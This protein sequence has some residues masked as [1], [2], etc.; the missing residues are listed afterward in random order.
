MLPIYLKRHRGPLLVT[1]GE[2][3]FTDPAPGERI[4]GWKSST[5]PSLGVVVP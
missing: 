2:E 5:W 4:R 3:G 1:I